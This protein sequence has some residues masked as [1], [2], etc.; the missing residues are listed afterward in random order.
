MED[1]KKLNWIATI[2]KLLRYPW[3]AVPLIVMIFAAILYF[4]NSVEIGNFLIVTILAFLA[5]DFLTIVFISGGH[6]IFQFSLIGTKTQPKGYAFII[7]FVVI[8][9]VAYV[10]NLITQ[11]IIKFTSSFY[12]DIIKVVIICLIL[13]VLV[14]LD[15]Y[16]KFF[17]RSKT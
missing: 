6:G 17:H 7:F 9:I 3:I 2:K 16:V 8:I 13:A 5:S 11:P 14:Y 4:S 15:M 10:V 12:S 1:Y